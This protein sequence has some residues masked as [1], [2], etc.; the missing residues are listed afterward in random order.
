VDETKARASRLNTE[1]LIAEALKGN[2]LLFSNE[3]IAEAFSRNL[4]TLQAALESRRAEIN[5][6]VGELLS[7][8]T[9]EEGRDFVSGL[10]RD[11]Q[12]VLI[13]LYFQLLEGVL[14]R[15]GPTVH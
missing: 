9:L 2:H 3:L 5:R 10:S 15:R 7:V 13:L 14:L 1:F 6:T 12:H 8:G 4:A 11:V